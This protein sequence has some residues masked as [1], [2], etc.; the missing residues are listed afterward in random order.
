M[1]V[2]GSGPERDFFAYLAPYS[3]PLE[4][5]IFANLWLLEPLLKRILAASPETDSLQ[6]TTTA[7]TVFEAGYK[8]NKVKLFPNFIIIKIKSFYFQSN[9]IAGGARA[10]VNHRIH[11]GHSFE[12]TVRHDRMIIDDERVAIR[13]D[14]FYPPMKVSPYGPF[15][16]PFRLIA[17]S[18][19]QVFTDSIV[20]PSKIHLTRIFSYLVTFKL[21]R[22][23]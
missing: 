8:V 1:T 16:G 13:V 22:C 20:A 7:L 12:E 19:K 10:L 23:T 6:R 3:A 5:L 9:V 11:P 21:I 2:F 4:R 14:S 18:V 15:V 17:R